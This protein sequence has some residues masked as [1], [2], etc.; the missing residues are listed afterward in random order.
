MKSHCLALSISLSG[1][2]KVTTMKILQRILLLVSTG[3]LTACPP[4]APQD[5]GGGDASDVQFV[6]PVLAPP[7]AGQGIQLRVEFTVPPGTE[8]QRCWRFPMPSAADME[9]V[10]YE[11]AYNEGSHHMNLFR[12]LPS[13]AATATLSPDTGLA[14][15]GSPCFNAVDFSVWDLVVGSQVGSLD[16]RLPAGVAYRIHA[17]SE[18]L[19]QSHFVNGTTQ[20]T[21]GARAVVLVNLW[22]ADPSTITQHMGTMFANNRGINLP[23][24]MDCEFTTRCVV[25]DA[26]TFVAL[27]GH[28]HSRGQQFLVNA[29][30]DGTAPGEQI[31]ASQAWSDPPFALLSTPL[32]VPA[33]GGLFY[34]CRYHNDTDFPIT[35]GPHVEFEEHCNLFAYYY[36][37]DPNSRARYCF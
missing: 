21:P 11:V 13:V 25:P 18:M 12:V 15:E 30:M 2:S 8:Q 20:S 1:P 37:V 16:W 22:T 32:S 7:P 35:F 6:E 27:T 24:Q 5:G 23:P 31:Y 19:L 3:L 36:P 17:H 34:T 33:G 26:A 4:P 9:I 28:F 14:G 29:S 10:R